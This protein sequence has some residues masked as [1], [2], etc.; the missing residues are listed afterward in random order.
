MDLTVPFVLQTMLREIYEEIPS[1][2]QMSGKLGMLT[3]K[4]RLYKICLLIIALN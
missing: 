4:D 1:N 2:L 3:D